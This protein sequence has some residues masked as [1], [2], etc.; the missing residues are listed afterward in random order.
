[1]QEKLQKYK[2]LLI[3]W[4]DKMNLVA[5]GTIADI[6]TR[7]FEDSAQL[8]DFLPKNAVIYDM[9]SGAGFPAVVLAIMGFTVVAI[10]SITKKAGFLLKLKSELDLP[11]LTVV[12][13]RLENFLKKPANL[14]KK[15]AVFTARAFAPLTR[16]LDFVFPVKGRLFLL[17]GRSV[18]D[19]ILA[20]KQKYK[21]DYKLYPS[22]TG[23]GFILEVLI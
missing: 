2:E 22:K 17:K 12:N 15:G 5:P 20:A 1:M 19:E 6:E 21:F 23:D 7:H 11:N 18:N 10:E 8:A 3:Q 4:N 9:G 16:I 14:P 13:D